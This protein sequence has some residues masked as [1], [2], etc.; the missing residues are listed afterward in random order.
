VLLREAYARYALPMAITEAHLHCTREEQ[1]RWFCDVWTACCELKHEGADIR[2]VTAWSLLGAFGW[3]KLLTSGEC[4]YEPGVFDLRAPSPRRTELARMLGSIGRQEQYHHAVL[5]EPGWWKRD[6]RFSPYSQIINRGDD[7]QAPSARVLVYGE[8]ALADTVCQMLEARGISLTRKRRYEYDLSAEED[9]NAAVAF[10]KPW[11]VISADSDSLNGYEINVAFARHCGR[12]NIPFLFFSNAGVFDET[13]G[14]SDAADVRLNDVEKAA[15]EANSSTLIVRTGALISYSDPENFA[16][17]IVESLAGGNPVAAAKNPALSFSYLPDAVTAAL[18]LMIDGERGV[19]HLA[20]PEM[21]SVFDVAQELARQLRMPQH[22][23]VRGTET[24]GIGQ[25][26]L[27]SERFSV[28]PSIYC[29]LATF[30]KYFETA[31]AAYEKILQ[32]R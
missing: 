12:R 11:A 27:R 17:R 16:R 30:A 10:L 31:A 28:M 5:E 26:M 29:A 24:Y 3:N 6:D 19:C 4:D 2:A 8:G 13:P 15:Q 7:G 20:H 25:R 1:M 32:K 9:L 14:E 18:D 22:L 21:M 23:V